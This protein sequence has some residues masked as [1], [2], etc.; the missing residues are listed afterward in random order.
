MAYAADIVHRLGWLVLFQRDFNPRT[1][2]NDHCVSTRL[3]G[4]M[5]SM[6][7]H[8]CAGNRRSQKLISLAGSYCDGNI[9]QC[10]SIQFNCLGSDNNQLIACI[11]TERYR[12]NDDGC[13]SSCT[14]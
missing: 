3:I 7:I 14:A 2:T 6:D 9:E 4:G 10:Y 12:A 1:P 5:F 11:D 13:I 8:R